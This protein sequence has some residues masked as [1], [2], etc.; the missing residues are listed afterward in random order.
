MAPVAEVMVKPPIPVALG[1]AHTLV[2]RG[3]AVLMGASIVALV[4]VVVAAV[5]APAVRVTVLIMEC[6]AQDQPL[7]IL[8]VLIL[9]GR[10]AT[11]VVRI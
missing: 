1:L 5:V 9:E 8:M 11:Q 10:V 2:V 4:V 6:A 3:V 7:I